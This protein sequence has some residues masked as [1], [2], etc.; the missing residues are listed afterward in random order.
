MNLSISGTKKNEYSSTNDALCKIK[1]FPEKTQKSNTSKITSAQELE[2]RNRAEQRKKFKC[3]APECKKRMKTENLARLGCCL[4]VSPELKWAEDIPWDECYPCGPPCPK[5]IPLKRLK[6]KF[7]DI[8]PEPEK[9]C[10]PEPEPCVRLDDNLKIKPKTLPKFKPFDDCKPCITKLPSEKRELP[11]LK[12]TYDDTKMEYSHTVCPPTPPVCTA[13]RLDDICPIRYKRLKKLTNTD[14][15]PCNLPLPNRHPPLKRLNFKFVDPPRVCPVPEIC[16]IPK[17]EIDHKTYKKLPKISFGTCEPCN[18]FPT[19]SP[20]FKRLKRRFKDT[21]LKWVEICEEPIKP[22]EPRLDDGIKIRP[23][24]LQ[25]IISDCVPYIPEPSYSPPKL[26]RPPKAYDDSKLEIKWDCP[27]TPLC[28]PCTRLDSTLC[29]KNKKLERYIPGKCPQCV[30]PAPDMYPPLRKLKRLFKDR[31]VPRE[32]SLAQE[33]EVTCERMDGN[34]QIKRMVL[35]DLPPSD[36]KPCVPFKPTICPRIIPLKPRGPILDRTPESP[37][38]DQC[39]V[40]P[41]R[42][43]DICC[44]KPKAKELPRF[45]P[46]MYIPTKVGGFDYCY[47]KPPDTGINCC[48]PNTKPKKVSKVTATKCE[49]E[50]D[51]L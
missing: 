21:D 12:K 37:V 6:I 15:L 47:E 17:H 1:N 44:V 16:E 30:L 5:D 49:C 40:C 43:D 31:D 7:K 41:P 22:C 24:K 27:V 4:E 19:I 9:V 34:I 45:N 23:K 46:R 35:P 51:M 13:V 38:P 18:D 11:R 50:T 20:K 14:C 26:K 42:L 25:K 2:E 10:P 36:C 32:C 3:D 8:A 33:E 48:R 28:D 29:P 39:N